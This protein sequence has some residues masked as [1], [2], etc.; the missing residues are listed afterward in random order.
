MI[1][2]MEK[3]QRLREQSRAWNTIVTTLTVSFVPS[4]MASMDEEQDEQLLNYNYE[5]LLNKAL[6]R[7][8]GVGCEV[9]QVVGTCAE[10]T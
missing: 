4:S 10:K 1:A 3:R 9:K 7:G 6:D 5:Q 8:E 2:E